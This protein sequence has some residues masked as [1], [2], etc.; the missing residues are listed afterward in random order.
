MSPDDAPPTV[1][2]ND[3][4]VQFKLEWRQ[5]NAFG[6][7]VTGPG[8]EKSPM[9]GAVGWGSATDIEIVG[10]YPIE[11]ADVP[12][13]MELLS[14]PIWRRPEFTQTPKPDGTG[15]GRDIFMLVEVDPASI[16]RDALH[17]G[18]NRLWVTTGK[19]RADWSTDLFMGEL[20]IVTCIADS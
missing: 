11:D 14:K 20:E 15:I 3:T 18:L 2:I 16:R 4:I 1:W 7:A 12:M 17:K 13:I 8:E 6:M 10:G 5:R 19:R 9:R